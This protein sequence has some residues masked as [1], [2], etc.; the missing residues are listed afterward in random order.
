MCISLRTVYFIMLQWLLFCLCNKL[1]H[2]HALVQPTPGTS[3]PEPPNKI[4][5]QTLRT[6]PRRSCRSK[7]IE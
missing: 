3:E 7:I 5:I 6:A 1:T 4:E 2:Y